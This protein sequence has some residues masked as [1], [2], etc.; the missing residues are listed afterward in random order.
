[1]Q[2]GEIQ[3]VSGK[4][5]FCCCKWQAAAVRSHVVKKRIFYRLLATCVSSLPISVFHDHLLPPLLPSPCYT[6]G[7]SLLNLL[8]GLIA[9]DQKSNTFGTLSTCRFSPLFKNNLGEKGQILNLHHGAKSVYE[10]ILCCMDK[11]TASSLL[12]SLSSGLATSESEHFETCNRFQR[13]PWS[14]GL[15]LSLADQKWQSDLPA[16]VR[17]GRSPPATWVQPGRTWA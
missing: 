10:E 7:C 17:F 9:Q 1:M 3:N 13:C 2:P 4:L 11:I 14:M 8:L 15:F 16:A 6:L 5:M 12:C